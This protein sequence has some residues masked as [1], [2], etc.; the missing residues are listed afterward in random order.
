MTMAGSMNAGR[1]MIIPNNNIKHIHIH[2]HEI[3]TEKT[4][5]VNLCVLYISTWIRRMM[6]YV[7]VHLNWV[8]RVSAGEVDGYNK[9]RHG[10]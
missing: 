2:E 1:F 9:L 4:S 5:F 10:A 8:D 6:P 7:C 3:D